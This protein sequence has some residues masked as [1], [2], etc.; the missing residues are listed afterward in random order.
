[1]TQ[2]GPRPPDL[3]ELF[4]KLR[5]Y[6]RWFVISGKVFKNMFQEK[7]TIN[8]SESF[9]LGALQIQILERKKYFP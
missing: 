7:I 5:Y 3:R 4:D 6:Y 1:M 9:W 8:L 2:F